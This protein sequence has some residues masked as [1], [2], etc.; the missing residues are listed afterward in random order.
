[1]T[2]A[3]RLSPQPPVHRLTVPAGPVDGTGA[4]GK[5]QGKIKGRG[6]WPLGKPVCTWGWCGTHQEAAACRESA[7]YRV[8]IDETVCFAR[9]TAMTLDGATR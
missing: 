4:R 3:R 1:M 9:R 6:T 7:Q 2:A 8:S 5:M